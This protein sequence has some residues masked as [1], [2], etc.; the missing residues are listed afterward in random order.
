M[1]AF[2]ALLLVIGCIDW[3][4]RRI[5]NSLC[6]L[7]LLSAVYAHL[8]TGQSIAT[9][10]VLVNL[11]IA[12]LLCLPGYFKGVLGGGDV[13]LMIALV[14]AWS[15]LF[16]L[17]AFALGVLSVALL[18]VV[19]SYLVRPTALTEPNTEYGTERSFARGLPLGT[20]MA[21]GGLASL[22]LS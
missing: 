18:M 14:P 8:I 19:Q 7:L 13:K 17:Q 4:Q 2:W 21:V 11:A 5:P 22:L 9:S 20:A 12:L 10:A 3:Q 15:T 6:A 16:L 1:L